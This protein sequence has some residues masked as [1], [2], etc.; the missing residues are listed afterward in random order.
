MFWLFINFLCST[1]V[2]SPTTP[3]ILKISE[4]KAY[5]PPTYPICPSETSADGRV[6]VLW[7][8]QPPSW[9]QTKA[10]R[11]LRE[12][13]EVPHLFTHLHRYKEQTNLGVSLSLK[14]KPPGWFQVCG[15]RL[16]RGIDAARTTCSL[17][18]LV[19]PFVMGFTFFQTITNP[20]WNF[21][22]CQ[23]LPGCLVYEN[24]Y[25]LHS[26]AT[27]TFVFVWGKLKLWEQSYLVALYSS[28]T[29]STWKSQ[30]LLLL[31]DIG[32][33]FFLTE[34][35]VYGGGGVLFVPAHW[36]KLCHGSIY[37]RS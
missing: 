31:N 7:N 18:L 6:P 22:F 5:P 17:F 2:R 27:Y 9:F 15:L 34:A 35:S 26:I 37:W 10:T 14:S 33:F 30:D 11:R 25:S 20:G 16:G 29:V 24:L 23:F 36:N 19:V 12:G 28:L 3:Q 8:P 1:A 13:L 32:E 4:V 21:S